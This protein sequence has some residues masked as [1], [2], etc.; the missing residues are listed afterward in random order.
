MNILHPRKIGWVISNR[1]TMTLLAMIT[2]VA[3]FSVACGTATGTGGSLRVGMLSDHAAW[4]PPKV[5]TMPDIYTVQHTYDVLAMKNADMTIQPML[6]K[7]WKPNADATSWTFEL[8]KGVYF[9]KWSGDAATGK[10]VRVKEFKAEDVIHTINTLF[11]QKSAIASA[12][13]EPANMVVLDDHTLRLD[14]SKPNAV[15]MDAL[16]KYHSQIIPAGID[17]EL[18]KTVPHGTG[19][20][21]VTEHITGERTTFV[22]NKNYW[23]D[24][25]PKVDNLT[26]VFLPDPTSRAEALKAGVIDMIADLDGPSIQPIQ[27]NAGTQAI[28]A[29]SGGYMAIWMMMDTKPW[30]NK[31]VRQALQAA[32]DRKSILQGAQQGLGGIAYD[33]PIVEN[34]P[35]F[36]S[37]CLPPEYNVALA[38]ELLAKAGYPNGI[39]LTLVT[40]TSGGSMV[41]MATVLKEKAKPAGFNITIEVAPED[42]FWSEVWL[43]K[44]FGTSWWG[45]RPPYEAYSVV[46][47]S[48]GDWNEAHY[49]S[50]KMDSLLIEA[51]SAGELAD[52]QRIYGEMQCLLVDEVPRIIPV[53][54]PVAIGIR[55]NVKGAT[56]LWDTTMS[57]HRVY[58]EE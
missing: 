30:D 26:F 40:S 39:D 23:W 53:F 33:H 50:P 28:I 24:N 38:K 5:L 51:Q 3:L 37:E 17:L 34:D 20:F 2:T 10:A 35:V 29:P 9:H 48:G 21:I 36:N 55:N 43:K 44:P 7:S 31:L 15:L 46:Y 6:A 14:F 27:N 41:D 42:G 25:H 32:T 19:P 47:K 1:T 45:G 56:P 12:M 13:V 4:L 22:K 54:R 52:Q 16:V 49:A 18:L 58:L 11:E 8:R 57:L